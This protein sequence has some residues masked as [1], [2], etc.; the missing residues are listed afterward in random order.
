[1]PD[2]AA[3]WLADEIVAIDMQRVR[4]VQVRH[5]DGEVVRVERAEPSQADFGLPDLEEA[6]S[7]KSVY[8]LNG[9]AS[10]F[11]DLRLEDVRPADE[12]AWPEEDVLVVEM[13]TFDG[14]RLRM[15]AITQEET[16]LA[17]FSAE[18]DP[19][20][21]EGTDEASG[22]RS[23]EAVQEEAVALAARFEGWRYE[24]PSWRVESLTKRRADL[25][26]AAGDEAESGQ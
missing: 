22:L 4:A 1:M 3:D 12:V 5:S 20:L 10:V 24:L 8:A 19:A 13:T 7:I 16:V 25:V 26:Q 9:M 15:N 14:L 2:E 6:E 21:R 11:A 18:Y 23:S 17:G